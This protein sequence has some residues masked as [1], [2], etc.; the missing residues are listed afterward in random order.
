MHYF[1]VSK[2]YWSIC[3]ERIRKAGFRIISTA[4][5]WNLH[6][7]RQG[8][9]DFSGRSDP[10]KDLVVFL[11]LSREFGFKIILKPGPW[12]MAQW[13]NG[14]I[15]D[16]VFRHPET[17]AKN[18]DG[19]PLAAKAD[20]GAI[21]GLTPSYLH[22]RFQILLRHYFSVFSEVVKNY[23]YPRGPVFLIEIDHE[24]SFCHNFD[25]YSGDYNEY[26][27]RSLFPKFLEV[28]HASIEQLN[29]IYKTKYKDFAEVIP[30]R[31]FEA[32]DPAQVV[33]HL[34]WIA[35]RE[36][37]VN[38]YADSIAELLSGAEM[39]AMFSRAC[40][41]NGGYNFPDL[42][43]ARTAE[44]TI[45]TTNISLDSPL[46]KIMDR[47]RS[48]SDGQ[49]MGFVS[50]FGVGRASPNPDVSE[51]FRPITEREV[52]RQ[53]TAALASGVKGMNFSMFVG[54]DR[55][56]GAAL[57]ESGAIGP[58]YEIIR[59]V[60]FQLAKI[61]FEKMRHFA[62][63]C[64][65]RYRPY[66]RGMVLGRSGPFSYLPDLVGHGFEAIGRDLM[67]CGF[68]YRIW[69]LTVPETLGNYKVLI[70]PLAE[71][72]SAEAQTTL[73]ELLRG[74]VGMVF[75]GLMPRFDDNMEPCDILAKALGVRTTPD[76]RICV[77]DTPAGPFVSQ[78]Y[79][80]IRRLPTRAKALVK[81]GAKI[82]GTVGKLGQGLWHMLTFDPASSG[83]PSHGQFFSSLWPS[84]QLKPLVGSPDSAVSV[85]LHTSD[86]CGLLYIIEN[87]AHIADWQD[88]STDA[89]PVIVW[90]DLAAAGIKSKRLKMMD[91][92]TEQ[93]IKVAQAELAA[94]LSLPIRPGDSHMFFV[95]KG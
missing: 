51:K 35:F 73:V 52:K 65:L 58:S 49:E 44:R 63:I 77:L 87:S 92:Y 11:E 39:S 82:Y 2:R 83:D 81:S 38:R 27:V 10:A 66:L 15:P 43:D 26:V 85:V 91:I 29:K 31:E 4:V 40:A 21:G 93:E 37:L 72:M 48:I 12:I 18:K 3:F 25:P 14:G 9:F 70:V 95:S 84:H 16:F 33:P 79:G 68:D 46:D 94:G 88:D 90:A 23:I 74:G 19:E 86:K 7:P 61:E 32:K 75:Y 57:S 80:N 50:S 53:L 41:W 6:E 64:L 69:D 55:W 34:D 47:G 89:R 28:K 59:R 5:P 45:F 71:Y 62:S 60:N 36:H 13:D 1:R 30:P 8:E 78:V 42:A 54:R 67:R 24:P 20:V 56:Y 17:A 22:T 76:Y